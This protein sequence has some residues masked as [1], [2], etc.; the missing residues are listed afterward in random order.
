MLAG[1]KRG[2]LR[3]QMSRPRSDRAIADNCAAYTGATRFRQCYAVPQ[4]GF[5]ETSQLARIY[6]FSRGFYGQDGNKPRP[7]DAA[8]ISDP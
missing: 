8:D 1:P 5:F 4:S 6:L 3:P 7:V 2:H